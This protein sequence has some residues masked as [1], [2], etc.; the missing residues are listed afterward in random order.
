MNV[1]AGRS[2]TLKDFESSEEEYSESEADGKESEASGVYDV[3]DED[4]EPNG[5]NNSEL[6]EGSWVKVNFHYNTGI[7]TYIG[8]VFGKIVR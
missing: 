3:T 4:T 5:V 2:I 8:K 1:P 7:K 6:S